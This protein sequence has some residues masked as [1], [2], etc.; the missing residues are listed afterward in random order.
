MEDIFIKI[1][2]MS[3]TASY[4]VVAL[5]ILRIAF[6]KIPRWLTCAL[7]GLVGL[8]LILPFSFES[9]LSLVP[10]SETIPTGIIYESS[11]Y[12]TSG[13]GIID[14]AAEHILYRT[15]APDPA[16]SANPLQIITIIAAAIWLTG[17]AA[18]LIYTI[19]SYILIK[20]KTRESIKTE[21]GIY[22]CDGI[23]SP[24]IL[25]II[26]PKIF[27][28]SATAEADTLLIISHEKAHLKRLDH[29]WK[30]LGFLILSVYWFNP[31]MWVAYILLCRDIEAACDEKVLKNKGAEVKKSYSEALIN[32]SAQRRLITACPLAFGE[33]DVKS[34]IKNI[35]SYKKP[36]LWIIIAALIISIVLSVCFMTNPDGMKL[37][38][39]TGY[40]SIFSDVEKIQIFIG[41]GHIYTTEDTKPELSDI[42]KVR[43]DKKPVDKSFT[44]G[45]RIEID[46][47]ITINID[48]SISMLYLS[49]YSEGS[50]R[51][52]PTYTIR[53]AE[54][55]KN[56]FSISNYVTGIDGIYVSV[57]TIEETESGLNF[58]VIW[59][60]ERDID[61]E[62]G[63]I[64]SL[65]RFTE[66]GIYEDVPFPENFVFLLP[67]YML[68]AGSTA[69]KAYHCPM[70][71]SDGEYR[72]T[73]T[74]LTSDG[75]SYEAKTVFFIGESTIRDNAKK[76]LTL[77]D[78][79]ALSEKGKDLS[80]SDFEDFAY[81]ETGS[82]LYIRAYK[83]DERFSLTIG[84]AGTDTEPMYIYLCTP[85]GLRV[86]IR[87]DDVAA[88]I[89]ENKDTPIPEP[90]VT[91]TSRAFPVD[92]TG[93]NLSEIMK[94][95]A[96]PPT[97]RDKLKTFAT[98]RIDSFNE[99]EQFYNHFESKMNFSL[100]TEISAY[101]FSEIK[102]IYSEEY[103]NGFFDDHSLL[104]VYTSASNEQSYFDVV[105]V[106]PDNKKL[107]INIRENVY[108]NTENSTP[109]GW[110]IIVELHKAYLADIESVLAYA[111]VTAELPE[112]EITHS[113]HQVSDSGYIWERS[114]YFYDNGTFMLSMSP[115][116][117][118]LEIGSFEYQG[119]L[120][121]LTSEDGERRYVFEVN[122]DSIAFRRDES[123]VYKLF[124]EDEVP[125]GAKFI[126]Q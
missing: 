124:T 36:A 63:E 123:V 111:G 26:K 55:L 113:Y 42:K 79:I 88:F 122:A 17:I 102:T 24:F 100:M 68:K 64:Y 23:G 45:F 90:A 99:L 112:P 58:N 15:A 118:F 91:F 107:Y 109:T 46:D 49:C 114:L 115:Y 4:F 30:P 3:I 60:N 98:V 66:E 1:L 93:N 87:G 105:S 39:I 76:L 6:R 19:V 33:T 12:I 78:V 13:I 82:G 2:N 71:L 72:F 40:E 8:R 11:P 104:I 53:N 9:I 51:Q 80:W 7:W 34:R 61:I 106:Q 74:F 35:L 81:V 31:L 16:D 57:E 73:T 86:D 62:Y 121:I 56:L 59:H 84:G 32:C 43:I 52:S 48:E 69:E 125:D 27:I 28:P 5:I 101:P 44:P 108:A 25:G 75:K 29:L 38:D 14:A 67:A 95:G 41:N 110:F 96:Y 54:V 94:Y 126:L 18:M 120:L 37:N 116:S 77:D 10:S 21:N 65:Q 22:I 47:E 92:R 50:L 89:E 70:K 117:S 119:D 103:Q 85:N 20:R 83:I 97:I